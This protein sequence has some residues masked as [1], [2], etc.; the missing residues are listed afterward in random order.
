MARLSFS[1]HPGVSLCWLY[2]LE[3]SGLPRR[4]SARPKAGARARKLL[5]TTCYDY[6]QVYYDNLGHQVGRDFLYSD[7][8]EGGGPTGDENGGTWGGG[9]S[10]A[11]NDDPNVLS[12]I[13]VLIVPPDKSVT[14]LKQVI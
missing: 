12:P 8:E 1:P 2:S 7:C 3:Q 10:G 14:N 9:S 5:Q 11:D 13:T 4:G 6:Y